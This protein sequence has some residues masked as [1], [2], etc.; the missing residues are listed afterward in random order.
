VKR[1]EVWIALLPSPVNRRPVLILSRDSLPWRRPEITV[2]YLTSRIRKS[3]A[4]VLL[5]AADDGVAQDCAINLDAIN[6]VPKKLLVKHRC[7]LSA[8][9]MLEV[10]KAIRYAL[11]M[12]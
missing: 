2:A 12:K 6:T 5:T 7:T 9:K 11:G 10:E 1:G 3:Q 4:Q 8:A